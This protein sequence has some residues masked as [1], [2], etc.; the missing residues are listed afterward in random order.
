MKVKIFYP[1]QNGNIELTKTQLEQLLE[2]AYDE[3]YRNGQ[4]LPSWSISTTPSVTLN[5]NTATKHNWNTYT[6]SSSDV[7]NGSPVVIEFNKDSTAA[8]NN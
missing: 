2:E 6:V 8:V 1:N 5:D 4:L 3:G 7:N